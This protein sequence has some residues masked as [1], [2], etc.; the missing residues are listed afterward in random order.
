MLIILMIIL[1][2]DNIIIKTKYEET[3][4]IFTYNTYTQ[5]L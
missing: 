2:N 4:F 5:K 1:S 3:Y